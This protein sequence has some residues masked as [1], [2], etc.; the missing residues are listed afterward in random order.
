MDHGY[1]KVDENATFHVRQSFY[2]VTGPA[3]PTAHP[4]L[5]AYIVGRLRAFLPPFAELFILCG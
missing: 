2:E 5:S 3:R 1:E 4:L